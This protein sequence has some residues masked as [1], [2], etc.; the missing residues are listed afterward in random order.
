MYTDQET[1]DI[2]F[3]SGIRCRFSPTCTFVCVYVSSIQFQ[4][5]SAFKR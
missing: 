4:V 5:L 2:K 3:L 1:A